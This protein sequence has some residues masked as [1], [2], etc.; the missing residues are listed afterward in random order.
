MSFDWQFIYNSRGRKERER[1]KERERKRERERERERDIKRI[2]GLLKRISSRPILTTL[3][4]RFL[5]MAR[6]E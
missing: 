3:T 6:T 1:E 4:H 5:L 2:E